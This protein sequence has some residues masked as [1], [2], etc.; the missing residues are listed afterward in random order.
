MGVG[1][2][3]EN[4]GFLGQDVVATLGYFDDMGGMVLERVDPAVGSLSQQLLQTIYVHFNS[5]ILYFKTSKPRYYNRSYT[6]I[7]TGRV[8]SSASFTTS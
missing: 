5:Q 8:R 6:Y 7:D 1:K 3:C 4:A 2:F